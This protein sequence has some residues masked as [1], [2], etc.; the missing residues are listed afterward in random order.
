MNEQPTYDIAVVGGGLVGTPLAILLARSGWRVVLLDQQAMAAPSVRAV[1]TASA[2]AVSGTTLNN[3]ANVTSASGCTAPANINANR[4]ACTA[5]SKA[6]VRYLNQHRLWDEAAAESCAINEVHVSHSGYFG[7]TRLTAEQENLDSLG[8]VVSNTAFLESLRTGLDESGVE[9]IAAANVDQMSS[10]DEGATIGYIQAGKRASIKARLVIAVD[11]ASSRLRE[12]AGIGVDHTDYDQL[13]VLGTVALSEEHHHVAFERFTV[14]GPLAM[15]PRPNQHASYVYCIDPSKRDAINN[16]DDAIFSDTLQNAFGFRLGRL[17]SVGQRVLVPLVRI[18]ARQQIGQ[19]LVLMGNAMRLL[20]P[21]AGQGY[22]LA[23]RDMAELHAQ[24]HMVLAERGDQADPGDAAALARFTQ[25]REN[26]QQNVVR[27]T[28]WMARGFRGSASM[29][30][31][32]RALGLLGLDNIAPLRRLFL[33]RSMGSIRNAP[34]T[35]TQ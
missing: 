10:N 32:A 30:S 27:M 3:T 1:A 8:W 16:M 2:N 35:A 29:P 7:S 34:D 9:L 17:Q 11:G 15:L 23:V 20:H 13:A 14:D 26:D 12:S 18:E 28:D 24:L 4:Q 21:V 22:N 5:L 19:R 6:T 31:H 25:A 33:S